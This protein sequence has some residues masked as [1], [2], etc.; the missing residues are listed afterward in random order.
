VTSSTDIDW[1]GLSRILVV[2]P[3]NLGDVL[4]AGPAL[5]ALAAAAPGASL[6]LLASSGG[7]AVAPLLP[8]VADV[9][10]VEPV[11]QDASGAL[12][13]DPAREQRLVAEVAGRRYDAAVV[14]TSFSQSPWPAAY[15]CYLA[16]VPIRVGM[17]GEFGGSLLT[18]WVPAA[19]EGTHQVDRALRMLAAVG[20]RDRGQ[21]L[22][23]RLPSGAAARAK[24][25]V[26]DIAPQGRYAVVLPGASCPSR[27]YD[28]ARF[29]AVAAELAAA[30]LPVAVVGSQ[31]E[32]SLV[33]AV[34]A[35]A[36]SPAV[37]PLTG[38]D[39]PAL[40]AL[41]AASTAVISNNSGGMHLADAVGTALVATFAG[42]EREAEYRPRSTRATLLRR[43]TTCSP[44]RTFSCPYAAEC[45]DIAPGAVVAAVHD[46]LAGRA[47]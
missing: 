1:A 6:H 3:D 42:T 9:L 38:L 2:R 25:A 11:W 24:A 10:V 29:G 7:A 34:V 17:S 40:A 33:E 41:L 28:R 32:R 23:V 31:R 13:L 19:P 37:R 5:R 14:L 16:G 8:E 47:A 22:A 12:P 39:V 21:H 18:H 4:L 43:P 30:G 26:A 27:R 36:H 15:V 20:V 35:A 46:L 44:C 45:L